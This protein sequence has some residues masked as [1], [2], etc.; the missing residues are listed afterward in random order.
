MS[1]K[2]QMAEDELT[3]AMAASGKNLDFLYVG[4]W[5]DP[6]IEGKRLVR[7]QRAV[8][9]RNCAQTATGVTHHD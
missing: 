2:V 1:N 9:R 6:S 5:A 3:K 8:K 7:A 4:A